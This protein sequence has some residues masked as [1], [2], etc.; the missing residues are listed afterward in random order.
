MQ[1]SPWTLVDAVKGSSGDFVSSIPTQQH[2]TDLAIALEQLIAADQSGLS[3]DRLIAAVSG[4]RTQVL[5][6]YRLLGVDVPPPTEYVRIIIEL[7]SKDI[8][9]MRRPREEP[10]PTV[11]PAL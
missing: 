11:Q 9:M 2:R 3:E 7:A 5:S 4:A 6:G 1:L 8:H 10:E